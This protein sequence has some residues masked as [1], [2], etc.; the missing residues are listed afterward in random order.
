MCCTTHNIC[1][2]SAASNRRL[3]RQP[4]FLD[5]D[6]PATAAPVR[7]RPVSDTNLEIARRAVHELGSR[8][9]GGSVWDPDVEVVNAAG[10][11]IET[12]YRG[13]E[14]LVRWWDD[15]AEAFGEVTLEL[16]DAI[17]VDDSRVLTAQRFAGRFRSTEIPFDGPW[18]SILW[19]VDRRVV[20]AEGHLTKRRAM[21]AAGLG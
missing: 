15:I 19:I 9:Y 13:H 1:N 5:G 6:R 8:D 18:A 16:E 2:I 7:L 14:G 10:W 20:R 3:S 21:R 11:V 17:E 4:G 12:T